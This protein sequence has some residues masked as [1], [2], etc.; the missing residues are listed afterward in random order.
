MMIHQRYEKDTGRNDVS[1]P[2]NRANGIKYKAQKKPVNAST[3]GRIHGRKNNYICL[4]LHILKKKR[5]KLP[6]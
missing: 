4:F 5:R 2:K 3:K 1:S 6:E